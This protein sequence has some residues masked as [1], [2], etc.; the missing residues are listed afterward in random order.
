MATTVDISGL[1]T[2]LRAVRKSQRPARHAAAEV[3]TRS[4][5][6]HVAQHAKR[7][8]NRY[9]RGWIE[10][11]RGAGVTGIPMPPLTESRNRERLMALF[12]EQ[13]NDATAELAKLQQIERSW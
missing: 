6:E 4:I 3:L 11:G 10:A 12:V 1:R 7:D 2:Q 9:V 5:V 8:T 13:Y